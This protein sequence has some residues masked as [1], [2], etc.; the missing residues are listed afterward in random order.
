MLPDT[1]DVTLVAH[2]NVAV[3]AAKNHLGTFRYDIAVVDTGIDGSLGTAVTDG[4]DLLDGISNLH[5]P[6]AAGE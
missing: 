1:P 5:E 3:I 4:L 6:A 2:G